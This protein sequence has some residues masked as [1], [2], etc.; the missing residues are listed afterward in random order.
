MTIEKYIQN[1]SKKIITTFWIGSILS[2]ILLGL[3]APGFGTHWIGLVSFLPLLFT[4]ENLHKKTCITYWKRCL[5]FSGVC[6]ITGGIASLI[7][8]YWITNSIHVFGHIPMIFSFVITGA[9]YGLEIGLQLFVYFAIPLLCI[10]KIGNWESLLRLSYVIAIDP[11]Y[12]RL[13]HWNFGGLTFSQFPLLEQVAD[14]IGSS[15]LIFFSLG[16]QFLLML[17]WRLKSACKK[18]NA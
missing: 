1:S 2:G 5:L 14:I 16:L 13:I 8:G 17:W 18:S 7:G 3:N 10:R 4:L 11:W 6:W 15:G 9:G 12:P